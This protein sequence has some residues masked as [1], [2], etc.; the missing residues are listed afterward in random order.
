M[1][2]IEKKKSK[3][4]KKS[5][6]TS[7]EK[8]SEKSK[9]LD[10]VASVNGEET[11]TDKSEKKKKRKKDKHADAEVAEE[12][13]EKKKKKSKK[14]KSSDSS[15]SSSGKLQ[16]QNGYVQHAEVGAMT[17][18]EAEAFRT[19]RA[20]GV[21]PPAASDFYKP[22]TSFD[23]LVPTLGQS[24][25][26]VTNYIKEKGFVTPSPIQA[27][28]WPPLLAGKDVVGKC[29]CC[30]CCLVVSYLVWSCCGTQCL[31]ICYLSLSLLHVYS[32][33]LFSSPLCGV[34]WSGG[35]VRWCSR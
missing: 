8:D 22:L 19:E 25:P 2:E 3:K 33:S 7:E 4:S 9:M 18:A 10:M 27:Q 28:C 29:C 1:S 16:T 23:H 15:S 21:Y 6:K 26:R 5:K 17:A 13:G 20:I 24:C 34:K 30:C 14:E 11:A 12:D 35:A 31:S 32:S